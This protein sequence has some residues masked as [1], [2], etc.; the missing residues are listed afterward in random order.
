MG[1]FLMKIE[2]KHDTNPSPCR[3][4]VILK[5]LLHSPPSARGIPMREKKHHILAELLRGTLIGG[6]ACI[7]FFFPCSFVAKPHAT[8]VRYGVNA[9][10][11]CKINQRESE[12]IR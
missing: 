2:Q 9:N 11:V 7:G 3:Q 5:R 8:N 12:K 10:L 4:P 1:F 6:T